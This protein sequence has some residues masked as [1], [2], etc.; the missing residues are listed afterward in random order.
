MRGK[1]FKLIYFSLGGSEVKEI[2]LDWKNVLLLGIGT[3]AIL[4][5]LIAGILAVFTDYFKDM[6]YRNLSKNSALLSQQLTEMDDKINQIHSKID[7]L[8]ETDNALR[9]FV[10]MEA[11]SQDVRN[12]GVGG[13]SSSLDYT[14][15]SDTRFQKAQDIKELIDLAERRIEFLTD[16][17]NKIQQEHENNT[18][19]LNH[20]PSIAPVGE[21]YRIT[22]VFGL[23]NHPVTGKWGKHN[24][25]DFSGRRGDPVYVTAAG[26]VKYVNHN[27]NNSNWGRVIIV[28]HGYGF[29]TTYAHLS[30]INVKLHE[31]VNR[32]Q[33]IGKVGSTGRTTGPHLHYEVKKNNTFVNPEDYIFDFNK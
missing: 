1:T 9:I 31:N 7:N 8:E 13:Y 17:R 22:D 30:S 26:T 10:D 14:L 12:V 32:F 27:S 15:T 29:E 18:D 20:T 4:G 19:R 25:M 16:S 11:N 5:I 28:D 24:G 21:G 2:N 6:R 23:R 33:T 3:F